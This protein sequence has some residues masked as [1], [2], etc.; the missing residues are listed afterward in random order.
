[1]S[2]FYFPLFIFPV[3]F[4]MVFIKCL[5]KCYCSFSWYSTKLKTWPESLH[6]VPTNYFQSSKHFPQA[7]PVSSS[8]E[9]TLYVVTQDFISPGIARI[10]VKFVFRELCPSEPSTMQ[11]RFCCFLEQSYV[12]LWFQS[13]VLSITHQLVGY[14]GLIHFVPSSHFHNRLIIFGWRLRQVFFFATL[15]SNGRLS[16]TLRGL[17]CKLFQTP[18]WLL[19]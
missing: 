16:R 3:N 14:P 4:R 2:T 10:H 17:F 8:N 15:E 12:I 19:H 9:C 11:Y 13:A 18:E 6:L 7:L 1:M 5:K